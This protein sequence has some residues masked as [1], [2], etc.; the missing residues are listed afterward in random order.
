MLVARAKYLSH[1]ELLGAFSAQQMAYMIKL[2]FPSGNLK[3]VSLNP[4]EEL[5]DYFFWLVALL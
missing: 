5:F 1:L 4:T 2:G 3:V